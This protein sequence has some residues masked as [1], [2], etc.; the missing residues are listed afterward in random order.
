[1]AD[2]PGSF[3]GNCCHIQCSVR[4]HVVLSTPQIMVIAVEYF[5][6]CA[7]SVESVLIRE[8]CVETSV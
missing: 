1:M 5:T 6:L 2:T 3:I 4:S 7:A 8:L